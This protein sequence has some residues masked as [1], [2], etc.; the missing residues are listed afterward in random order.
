MSA[1]I[2]A[3]K[4]VVNFAHLNVKEVPSS[5]REDTEIHSS[6]KFISVLVGEGPDLKFF[7]QLSST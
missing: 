6:I 7:I 4:S 1:A 3:F 2:T 5:A